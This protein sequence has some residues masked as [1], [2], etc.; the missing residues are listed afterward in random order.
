VG[1][2]ILVR[3]EGKVNGC[4]VICHECGDGGGGLRGEG[5]VAKVAWTSYMFL[6]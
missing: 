6:L 5:H 1:S 3:V 4:A 2:T